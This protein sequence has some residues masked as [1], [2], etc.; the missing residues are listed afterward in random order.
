MLVKGG[1]IVEDYLKAEALQ[2]SLAARVL[3]QAIKTTCSWLITHFDEEAFDG[4]LLLSLV[5]WIPFCIGFTWY[6]ARCGLREE[7]LGMIAGFLGILVSYRSGIR[8]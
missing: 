2:R 8:C 5:A 3:N 6:S 4:I 7:W 1:T